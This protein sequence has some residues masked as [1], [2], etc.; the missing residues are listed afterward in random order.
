MSR[1]FL[2]ENIPRR[3]RMWIAKRP[4]YEFWD[5]AGLTALCLGGVV[6]SSPQKLRATCVLAVPD[7]IHSQQPT[8]PHSVAFGGNH[9]W[10]ARGIARVSAKSGSFHLFEKPGQVI[11]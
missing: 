5:C 10:P 8:V 1:R 6:Q 4:H 3:K 7:S 11:R 9:G 2:S